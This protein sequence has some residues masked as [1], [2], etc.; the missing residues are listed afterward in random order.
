MKQKYNQL[1]SSKKNKRS[2]KNNIKPKSL[3]FNDLKFRYYH[4]DDRGA[5]SP[6]V[7]ELQKKIEKKALDALENKFNNQ[8]HGESGKDKVNGRQI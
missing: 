7:Y 1:I 6:N 2:S 5:I 3:L 4:Y 8:L